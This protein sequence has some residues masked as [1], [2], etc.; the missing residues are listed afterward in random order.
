MYLNLLH[1]V[2]N[3]IF[4]MIFQKVLISPRIFQFAIIVTSVANMICLTMIIH[5][6]WGQYREIKSKI[7]LSL[8]LLFLVFMVQNFIFTVYFLLYL[9]KNCIDI[10]GPLLF[11]GC[12]FIVLTLFLRGVRNQI[13]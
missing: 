1:S 9:P 4:V 2:F 12:E 8:I 3:T 10:I 6:Y 7:T 5:N 13:S 11:L